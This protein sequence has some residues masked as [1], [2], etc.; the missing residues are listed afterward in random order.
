VAVEKDL[1]MLVDEMNHKLRTDGEKHICMASVEV[2]G[3]SVFDRTVS[4]RSVSKDHGLA[5]VRLGYALGANK[6]MNRLGI[7]SFIFAT[8]F[9]IDELAQNIV[10]IALTKTPQPYYEDQLKRLRSHV[11][12]VKDLATQYNKSLEYEALRTSD[13]AGGMFLLL[14]FVG[15]RGKYYNG[16]KLESDIT[17]GE[18]L[19][20]QNNN[21]GVAFLPASCAG[22]DESDLKF[23]LSLSS[24]KDQLQLGMQ[25]VLDFL[26]CVK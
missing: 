5:G 11:K 24:P 4:L 16:I 8:C 2:K 19:V 18:L 10:A 3:K 7:S 1:I 13:P 12:L 9:N 15:V 26:L 6:L 25:R 21:A 22:F 17:L 23:R 20:R 14:E